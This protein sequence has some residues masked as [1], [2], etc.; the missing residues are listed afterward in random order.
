MGR[1][2]ESKK[3]GVSENREAAETN[4]ENRETLKNEYAFLSE[5]TSMISE[6]ED[7]SAEAVMAV[8][9]VG[10]QKNAELQ[11]EHTEIEEQKVELSEEITDELN[12]L[13][14]GLRKMERLGRFEFGKGSVSDAQS[15]Y[16]KQIEKYKGLLG[17]LGESFSEANGST[18]GVNGS[19]GIENAQIE[20]NEKA[21]DSNDPM[22]A[23]LNFSQPISTGQND[24]MFARNDNP[25]KDI[26]DA[27]K[28]ADDNYPKDSVHW[29]E[30]ANRLLDSIRSELNKIQDEYSNAYNDRN[31]KY[32]E[33]GNYVN[34]N[35]LTQGSYD[36]HYQRLLSEYESAQNRFEHVKTRQN[37]LK[38]EEESLSLQ[39]DPSMQTTFVGRNGSNFEDS[40][41]G[42]I[43][44]PQGQG[45]IVD[46][47]GTRY[48]G[49]C[50][51]NETCSIVN[52][53]TGS[54]LDEDYGI[55]TYTSMNLC[56]QGREYE[57]NGGTSAV[58]R[59]QFL[60]A[61]SLSFQR[62]E[63]SYSSGVEIN[64]DDVA[65]RFNNG[66]SIGLML[67]AQ[68]LSQPEIFSRAPQLSLNPFDKKVA[69][70]NAS[71][72]NAN[73]AT[74]VAGFSYLPDGSVAGVWIN[75]T[76]NWAG[77]NRVY[78]DRNKFNEMQ[79]KTNGLAFEFSRRRSV[80]EFERS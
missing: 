59:A 63:G 3:K 15:D 30:N 18:E 23:G 75:D 52:M 47:N 50:G 69:E 45:N 28:F 4:T 77:S 73:H 70:Y 26:G 38:I 71:R 9:N 25:Q 55:R 78:I 2:Y 39:I 42:I 43:T 31:S 66:E 29:Q 21:L 64:L 11:E 35:G 68:D 65:S 44:S 62:I 22:V 57:S 14:D 13:N 33:L 46:S 74:T 49:T 48:G 51:I 32:A 19:A 61:H 17:N 20:Q 7:E 53:Q 58:G 41:N 56:V 67:R 36:E 37:Q 27:F 34:Q 24:E 60:D 76:G 16:K 40:Y 80:N 54:E 79:K 12:K 5:L 6:L 10:E 1:R 8:E 72:F